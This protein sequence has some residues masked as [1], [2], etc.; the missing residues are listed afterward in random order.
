[1][2]VL[3]R[4]EAERLLKSIALAIGKWNELCDLSPSMSSCRCYAAPSDAE[5][6]Y[7]L[8]HHL[9]QWIRADGWVLLQVDNST[10]PT[11]DEV[12]IFEEVSFASTRR[13]LV[14]E[15]RS[16]LLEDA[17]F[18]RRAKLVLLVYFCL[19]FGWHIHLA[20]Q[21]SVSGQRLSLQ[22]GAIYFFGDVNV[23]ARAEDLILATQNQPRQMPSN[24]GLVSGSATDDK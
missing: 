3:S 15:E 17:A 8:A 1:M 22:D 18:G 9:C 19:L 20:A 23:L 21:G 16:F 7:V 5:S 11:D 24:H 2:K 12:A 13:W 6:L 10:A 4:G 14:G